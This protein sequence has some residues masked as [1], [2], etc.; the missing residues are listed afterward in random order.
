VQLIGAGEADRAGLRAELHSRTTSRRSGA[1]PPRWQVRA[2]AADVA[3][4]VDEEAGNRG[5]RRT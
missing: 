1:V 3:L 4:S 5:R 2:H